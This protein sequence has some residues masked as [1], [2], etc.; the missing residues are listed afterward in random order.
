MAHARR[1]DL[2]RN[3]A[4]S[5]IR[6]DRASGSNGADED[7]A[8]RAEPDR[9]GNGAADVSRGAIADAGAPSDR[10]RT[11]RGESDRR[12]RLSD[13][14]SRTAEADAARATSRRGAD[15]SRDRAAVRRA[16]MRRLRRHPQQSRDDRLGVE[17]RRG[18][19]RGRRRGS[20]GARPPR[21]YRPELCAGR[22][23]PPY[24]GRRERDVLRRLSW[25]AGSVQREVR[26]RA[27]SCSGAAMLRRRAV[28][29]RGLS[30]GSRPPHATFDVLMECSSFLAGTSLASV[31]DS[32]RGLMT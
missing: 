7:A 22:R 32:S 15:G 21:L 8:E 11:T 14:D 10:D 3:R 9:D 30:S 23:R 20:S 18:D 29:A 19:R 28:V 1:A 6:E 16:A 5:G 24:V 26:R 17:P 25:P 31:Y 12:G 27:L 4:A 13:R 2:F